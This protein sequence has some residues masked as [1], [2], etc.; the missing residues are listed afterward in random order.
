LAETVVPARESTYRAFQSPQHLVT[1]VVERNIER[2]QRYDEAF[3][4]GDIKA[5]QAEA[6]PFLAQF[7]AA[8]AAASPLT[9]TPTVAALTP[10]G[11]TVMVGNGVAANPGGVTSGVLMMAGTGDRGEVSG[12]Q[13]EPASYA[14]GGDTSSSAGGRKAG[15]PGPEVTRPNPSAGPYQRP[16]GAGPTAAQ[17]RAVQGKPCVDCGEVTPRQVADHKKPLVVEHYETGSVD[18]AKQ[19]TVEAVQPHCPTCS[20]QQGAQLAAFSRRMRDWLGLLPEE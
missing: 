15:V 14:P 4:R 2:K 18:V 3:E 16:R 5:A 8:R 1:A 20:S 7:V 10:E 6:I 13:E 9:G 11:A 19:S 12:T 17:R